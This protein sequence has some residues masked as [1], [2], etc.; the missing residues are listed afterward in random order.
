MNSVKLI[1]IRF[2]GKKNIIFAK[3]LFTNKLKMNR[4][5]LSPT[6]ELVEYEVLQPIMVTS[7]VNIQDLNEIEDEW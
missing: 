7:N 4:I 2:R 5:Y 1:L 3:I 6:V